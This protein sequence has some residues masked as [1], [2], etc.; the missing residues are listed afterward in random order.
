MVPHPRGRWHGARARSSERSSS[1]IHQNSGVDRCCVDGQFGVILDVA[2]QAL[3]AYNL[4]FYSCP[5]VG[6]GLLGVAGNLADLEL[7]GGGWG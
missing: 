5:G 1:Y 6:F 3:L 2:A 4:I 7:H